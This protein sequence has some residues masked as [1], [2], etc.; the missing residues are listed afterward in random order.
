MA[1]AS[2]IRAGRAYIELYLKEK[3][4]ESIAAIGTKIRGLGAALKGF[5]AGAFG[6]SLPEPV[7]QLLHMAMSAGRRLRWV[8]GGHEDLGPRW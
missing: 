8:P 2:D 1:S 3:V 4:A 6:G 5:G 7:A